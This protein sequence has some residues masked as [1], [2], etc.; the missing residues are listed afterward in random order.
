M[1]VLLFRKHSKMN[2]G[3]GVFFIRERPNFN[4]LA[5]KFN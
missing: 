2:S 1:L 5:G 3:K 4:L